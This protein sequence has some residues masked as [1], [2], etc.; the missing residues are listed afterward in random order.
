M[1]DFVSNLS[2]KELAKKKELAKQGLEKL[3]RDEKKALR[4]LR[5]LTAIS[6]GVERNKDIAQLLDT[7]KSFASKKVKALADEGLIYKE[8]EGKKTRYKVNEPKVLKFLKSK[9]HI[10]KKKG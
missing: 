7:D 1:S 8:G 4:D 9:V 6:M 3:S 5:I 10:T 2:E